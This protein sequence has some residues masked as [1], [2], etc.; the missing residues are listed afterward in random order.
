MKRISNPHRS[1]YSAESGIKPLEIVTDSGKV[2]MFVA[3]PEGFI[4]IQLCA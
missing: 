1:R 3:T 4:K 2:I